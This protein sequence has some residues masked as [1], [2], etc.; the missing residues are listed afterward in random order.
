MEQRRSVV[1]IVKLSRPGPTPRLLLPLPP[2][3]L[4]QLF[5]FAL[6]PWLLLRLQLRRALLL[7]PLLGLLLRLR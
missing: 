5:L 4:L 1:S 7:P 2:L 6:L 3:P